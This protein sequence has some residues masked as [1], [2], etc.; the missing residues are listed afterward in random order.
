MIFS[1]SIWILRPPGKCLSSKKWHFKSKLFL[2]ESE[3]FKSHL[4]GTP[5][6]ESV[7]NAE[8]TLSCGTMSQKLRHIPL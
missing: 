6:S 8:Y 3:F 1:G 5:V 4:F 2:I 7:F